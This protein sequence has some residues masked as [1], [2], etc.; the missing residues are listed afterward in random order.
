M[1]DSYFIQSETIRQGCGSQVIIVSYKKFTSAFLCLFLSKDLHNQALNNTRV[2]DLQ[3]GNV[4]N[5]ISI[6]IC[7]G[8]GPGTGS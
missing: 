2:S 4:M 8:P 3:I 5:V 1:T 7:P 6:P